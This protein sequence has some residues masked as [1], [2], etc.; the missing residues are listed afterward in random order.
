MREVAFFAIGII[1]TAIIG[2]LGPSQ[3]V[4]QWLAKRTSSKAIQ[5]KSALLGDL[6]RLTRLRESGNF[7]AYI[8][9]QILLCFVIFSITWIIGDIA[10]AAANGLTAVSIVGSGDFN[11]SIDGFTTGAWTFGSI[12]DA[13]GMLL[14]LR[15]ALRGY[16]DCRRMNGYDEF[17]RFV[18]QQVAELEG[19]EPGGK[20]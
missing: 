19:S 13:A 16:R 5:R 1:V 20:D 8:G 6:E 15:I 14:V 10:N 9:G 3:K 7:A 4:Q 12:A 11:F 17:S 2:A 18:T